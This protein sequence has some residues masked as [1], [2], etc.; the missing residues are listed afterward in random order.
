[1]VYPISKA[2]HLT[3]EKGAISRPKESELGVEDSSCYDL[4]V[5]GELCPVNLP[6]RV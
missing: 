4:T 3:L 5:P 2:E 1:M 6:V